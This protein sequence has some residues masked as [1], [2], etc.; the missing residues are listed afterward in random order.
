MSSVV[1]GYSTDRIESKHKFTHLKK[2]A[3]LTAAWRA[4]LK[5]DKL[6]P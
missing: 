3:V 6:K 1:A 5:G 4:G 2:Q